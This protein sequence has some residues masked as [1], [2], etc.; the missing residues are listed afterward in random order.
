MRIFGAAIAVSYL[1]AAH[2]LAQNWAS[3]NLTVGPLTNR[4]VQSGGSNGLAKAPSGSRQAASG[5][6]DSPLSGGGVLTLS[7]KGNYLELPAEL[8][9]GLNEATLECWVKWHSFTAN[10]H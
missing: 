7:G 9:I 3:S 1:A 6:S 5:R 8:F 10:E 4:A 2:G